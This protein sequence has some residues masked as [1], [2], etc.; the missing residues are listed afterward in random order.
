MDVINTDTVVRAIYEIQR[1]EHRGALVSEI[2]LALYTECPDLRGVKTLISRRLIL[3]LLD[4]LVFQ[5]AVK[6]DDES[7]FNNSRS[8]RLHFYRLAPEVYGKLTALAEQE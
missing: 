6:V 4:G 7:F 3:G 8:T 2:E 5:D 1:S